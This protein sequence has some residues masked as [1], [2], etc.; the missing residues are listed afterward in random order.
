MTTHLRSAQ[1]L[2]NAV[3]PRGLH[4]FDQLPE[5]AI[6]KEFQRELEL[7]RIQAEVRARLGRATLVLS[8]RSDKNLGCA[9]R[10]RRPST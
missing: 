10:C 8:A 7:L 4:V 9:W 5:F 1:P 6:C 3:Q 2:I